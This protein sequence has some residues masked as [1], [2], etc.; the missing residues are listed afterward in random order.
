MPGKS[1]FKLLVAEHAPECIE[2]TAAAPERFPVVVSDV[3]VDLTRILARRDE[4]PSEGVPCSADDLVQ[5]WLQQEVIPTSRHVP[6][7]VLVFDK[8]GHVTPAKQA[9]QRR[10]D[11]YAAKKAGE[12]SQAE[13]DSQARGRSLIRSLMERTDVALRTSTANDVDGQVAWPANHDTVPSCET[14]RLTRSTW[15]ALF[16]GDRACK[17]FIVRLFA[18]RTVALLP[19]LLL[20]VGAPPS[21][22]VIV[23]AE[24][25]AG[26][27][28]VAVCRAE[29]VLAE[30]DAALVTELTNVDGEC[31]LAHLVHLQ[32]PSLR[33]LV[34]SV[35]G[36]SFLVRTV[37]TDLLVLNSL[38]CTD[39]AYPS[40]PVRVALGLPSRATLRGS[41]PIRGALY[42]FDPVKLRRSF[43]ALLAGSVE[44][45]PGLVRFFH[46]AGS[47]F[48]IE[49]VPGM[50]CLSAYRE[51]LRWTSRNPKGSAAEFYA[52][53]LA[54]QGAAYVT[55]SVKA[56]AR[57]L[58]R[59]RRCRRLLA[60]S[61]HVAARVDWVVGDYWSG[62]NALSPLGHGYGLAG[63]G[64]CFAEDLPSEENG[65]SGE[66]ST[67]DG[68]NKRRCLRDSPVTS[69][70]FVRQ[71]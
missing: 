56:S 5:R 54:R 30:G 16:A 66:D 64:M 10:R 8:Y 51:Y 29:G 24:N 27:A 71:E 69:V 33:G 70:Y 9:E 57:T 23:D 31:D 61:N 58:D 55:G 62:I 37:D 21:H 19:Q 2:D 40:E 13:M 65:C 14:T 39:S 45:F 53:L 59:R 6:C 52:Q 4:G 18:E 49:G 47:D 15:S 60:G 43:D 42:Y 17:R 68:R 12:G 35:S 48:N 26:V 67:S 22:A 46:F 50:S 38:R 32:S 34:R 28:G 1:D 3:L 44:G 41:A 36:G 63:D 11:T 7:Q 25:R 20:Q